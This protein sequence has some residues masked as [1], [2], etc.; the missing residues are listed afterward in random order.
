MAI[1]LALGFLLLSASEHALDL[2]LASGRPVVDGVFLNGRG[3][4]RFLIDT[5]AQT[6]QI[7]TE[8]AR[9]LGL[10]PT[11]QV[12]VVTATGSMMVPGATL[13]NLSAGTAVAIGQEIL[14]T[15]LGAIR[16]TASGVQG[17]LGQEFLSRF[18]YL[19]DFTNRR[20]ILDSAIP[21][22]GRRV[23]IEKVAGR[24]VIDTNH[25]RL[26]LD[27]GSDAAI[28]Y[29]GFQ[30]NGAARVTTHSGSAS[31]SM[32]AG[33]RVRIGGREYRPSKAAAVAGASP[34]TD[35]I[36]PANVFGSLFVS[37]SGGFVILDADL[38]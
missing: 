25:G 4:F 2:H 29:R 6:N 9:E 38:N 10:E 26:V 18:D 17:V 28:V 21:K 19:L 16:S 15:P 35:G 33:F 20:L 7:D 5:G 31:A 12:E 34:G 27:S 24:P 30:G 14:F 32:I 1:S 23:N 37:N 8:A 13:A 36:L 22:G 11:F 3:P